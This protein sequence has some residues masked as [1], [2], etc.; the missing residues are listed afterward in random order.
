MVDNPTTEDHD[1]YK[2]ALDSEISNMSLSANSASYGK[3][4]NEEAPLCECIQGPPG[5]NLDVY[6]PGDGVRTLFLLR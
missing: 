2:E 5:S 6:G 3:D 1:L 4:H